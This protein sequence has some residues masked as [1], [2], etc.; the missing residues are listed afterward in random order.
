MDPYTKLFYRKCMIEIFKNGD[1]IS[2]ITSA[3]QIAT[4]T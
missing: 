2:V 4:V 3:W 1:Q